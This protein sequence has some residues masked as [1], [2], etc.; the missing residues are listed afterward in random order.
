MSRKIIISDDEKEKIIS[1]IKDTYQCKLSDVCEKFKYS[2][3]VIK[4]NFDCNLLNSLLFQGVKD[5]TKQKL[6]EA[7]LGKKQSEVT[8]KKRSETMRATQSNFSE[9]KKQEIIQKR[10]QTIITKHG[11]LKDYYEQVYKKS[12]Q[13][14]LKRYGNENYNN[15]EKINEQS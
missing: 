15:Q 3:S 1:F 5:S 14:K 10:K 7:N 8:K 2:R 6:R 12:S 4:S 11:S 9:E 13:T